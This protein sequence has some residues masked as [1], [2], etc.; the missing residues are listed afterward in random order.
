MRS[1]ESK[2][3]V[4]SEGDKVWEGLTVVY[5]YLRARQREDRQTLLSCL[6]EKD[7]RQCNC[8]AEDTTI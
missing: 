4:Q 1:W 2:V 8:N 3:T 5:N 7:A 6:Y